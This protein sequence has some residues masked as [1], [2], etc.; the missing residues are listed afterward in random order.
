MILEN[1]STP[2]DDAAIDEAATLMSYSARQQAL[3][4]RS[5][6]IIS[7]I[8]V[9]AWFLTGTL[10]VHDTYGALTNIGGIHFFVI[11]IIGFA[12]IGFALLMGILALTSGGENRQ[13]KPRSIK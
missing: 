5:L 4:L 7:V 11:P 9:A 13:K 2:V 12:S 10:P 1:L 8:M 3:I 6:I